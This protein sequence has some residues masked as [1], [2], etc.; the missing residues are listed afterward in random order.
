MAYGSWI[1]RGW[2]TVKDV[3]D[4]TYKQY[5]YEIQVEW[6]YKQDKIANKTTYGATRIRLLSKNGHYVQS[7][8]NTTIG[9]AS[10]VADRSTTSGL[11]SV[12]A[13]SG[14]DVTYDL[15]D[16]TR[17]VS[18]N[19]DGT[20]SS[21]C[22]VHGLYYIANA[23]APGL[24]VNEWYTKDVTNLIPAFDR[25]AGTAGI[26]VEDTTYDSITLTLTSSVQANTCRYRINGEELVEFSTVGT[27]IAN[28]GGGSISK[29]ITGLT[30][31]TEY[32]IEFQAC[33][34]TNGVWSDIVSTNAKTKEP[35]QAKTLIKINGLWKKG[36]AFFKKDGKWHKAKK[37]YVKVNGSWM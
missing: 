27:D 31:N 23:N 4:A 1:N 12:M 6:G 22:N 21:T 2:V 37:V 11:D 17:E 20:I 28:A 14:D 13:K 30:P 18:H 9:I 29:T 15:T 3:W 19:A 32:T 35:D 33:K 8:G 26:S 34:A 36:K 16:K 24:P 5:G 10:S 7:R 25:S